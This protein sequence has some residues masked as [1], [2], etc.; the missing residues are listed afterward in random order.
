MD[1]ALNN[2]LALLSLIAVVACLLYTGV[3]IGLRFLLVRLTGLI[4]VLLAVSFLTFILGYFAPGDTVTY[5]LGPHLDPQLAA[6]LRHFYGLDLPWYTQ[7]GNFLFRLLHFDLGSSYVSRDRT[8]WDL[9]GAG[10]PVS[11][12]L[13]MFSLVAQVILLMSSKRS[14]DVVVYGVWEHHIK[15]TGAK[16]DASAPGSSKRRVGSKKTLRSRWA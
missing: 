9:L 15:Q 2:G 10:V 14:K 3:R 12:E 11:L 7:Y 5:Q 8:V 4:F 6:T 1:L 16:S 13:G